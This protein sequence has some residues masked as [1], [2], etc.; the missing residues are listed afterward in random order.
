VES[1][2]RERSLFDILRVDGLS[3][4]DG[5]AGTLTEA[6]AQ[7]ANAYCDFVSEY[8]GLIDPEIA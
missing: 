2:L 8:T 5:L 7:H 4:P 6:L 1:A 3:L